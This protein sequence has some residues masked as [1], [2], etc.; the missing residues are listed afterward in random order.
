MLPCHLT[1]TLPTCCGINGV[2]GSQT[3]FSTDGEIHHNCWTKGKRENWV[4]APTVL[5]FLTADAVWPATAAPVT[6]PS[7]ARWTL[8]AGT[9]SQNKLFITLIVSVVIASARQV[10]IHPT[11][12]TRER[13]WESYQDLTTSL[14]M[15]AHE[16]LR[17][18]NMYTYKH[19]HTLKKS[20]AC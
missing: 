4:P 10:I 1:F 18:Q 5:Y 8:S 11:P 16:Y 17:A 15:Y 19:A 14:R 7:L 2:L 9:V 3:D 13:H 20:L 6:K 12:E